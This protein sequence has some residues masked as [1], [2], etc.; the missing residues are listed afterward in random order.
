MEVI[1]QIDISGD[2]QHQGCDA[3][4]LRRLVNISHYTSKVLHACNPRTS[5]IRTI[6]ILLAGV[7]QSKTFTHCRCS[8]TFA[9]LAKTV[10]I[11]TYLSHGIIY[12]V[13][14]SLI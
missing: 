14:L 9:L 6:D 5:D 10:R 2:T 8:D 11:F 13:E 7:L 1:Q 4:T 3:F 12:R